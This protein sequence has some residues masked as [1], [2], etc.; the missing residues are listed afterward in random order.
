[1]AVSDRPE[2]PFT[3]EPEAIEGSYSI[4]PAV[5]GDDDGAFYMVFGGI[6][7]GQLQKYRDNAY[8]ASHREPLPHQPALGPRIA[9]LAD[10]MTQFAEPSRE[11]VILDE[12]GQPLLAGDHARRYFEGPWMHAYQGRY[13]LSYST[14]DT[15]LLCYATSDNP[16]GPYTYQGP[17]LTEVVGW[18]THHSICEFE[19]R[20][21]L[22]YHDSL[23]S[24]GVT[25]LRSIKMAELRYDEDGAI[26]C[27]H[28]YGE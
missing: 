2:G 22:F 16:Y 9:R 10:G 23:L 18:T 24:G 1:V 13:Y 25:H 21:Y 14:G 12:H 3:P 20:W 28:P 5:F 15:H 7:G 8:A 19:G 4:D 6:W 26:R 27:L 17:I 11:I